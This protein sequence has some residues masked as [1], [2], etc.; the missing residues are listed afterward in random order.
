MN[1]KIFM[2]DETAEFFGG[3][4]MV[5][6]IYDRVGD[7][8]TIILVGPNDSEADIANLAQA[9]YSSS[10]EG[11]E[12]K[13]YQLSR[14]LNETNGFGRH[15]SYRSADL[16]SDG[17]YDVRVAYPIIPDGIGA[18]PEFE[19]DYRLHVLAH[20][21]GHHDPERTS[22][23]HDMTTIAE[24]LES[25]IDADQD[26]IR[27]LDGI[28]SEGFA[29]NLL[30]LRAGNTLGSIIASETARS[31]FPIIDERILDVEGRN[32]EAFTHT[33]TAGITLE[34][35]APINSTTTETLNS[36]REFKGEI[37]GRIYDNEMEKNPDFEIDFSDVDTSRFALD[38]I[39]F[40]GTIPKEYPEAVE[41][42]TPFVDNIGRGAEGI[43]AASGVAGMMGVHSEE[44][45][46]ALEQADDQ[47]KQEVNIMLAFMKDKYPDMHRDFMLENGM[48]SLMQQNG[49]YNPAEYENA[50]EQERRIAVTAPAY[51]AMR[52]LNAE[53]AF[54]DDPIQKRL[55]DYAEQ[56]A[57][58]RPFI[59]QPEIE[60]AQ[61]QPAP[62]ETEPNKMI[63]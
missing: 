4:E 60:A 25:E 58:N 55:A 13:P 22:P 42:L 54:D 21:L 46:R 45:N 34:N 7:G 47:L 16:D 17:E 48:G 31:S 57:Q 11:G 15:G 6:T 19:Q 14:I 41:D 61:A 2:T 62:A 56:D 35:E 52:E 3:R 40:A 24:V 50:T 38:M 30:A 49:M 29:E 12:I 1:D 10:G 8:G 37:L 23:E 26:A 36:L 33:T 43:L 51:A 20:E 59:Y 53:G 44:L 5:Q 18:S 32:L 39:I 63:P 9:A 27:A 28:A